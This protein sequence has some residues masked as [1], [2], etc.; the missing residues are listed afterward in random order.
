[1]KGGGKVVRGAVDIA[2]L[3]TMPQVGCHTLHAPVS[4]CYLTRYRAASLTRTP[5]G[6]GGLS[7]NGNPPWPRTPPTALQQGLSSMT[8]MFALFTSTCMVSTTLV[9]IFLSNNA[10][11]RKSPFVF[12]QEIRFHAVASSCRCLRAFDLTNKAAAACNKMRQIHNIDS[13]PPFRL[14]RMRDD[15]A[16][17]A[18][19]SSLFLPLLSLFLT[20][21]SLLLTLSSLFRPLHSACADSAPAY[22]PRHRWPRSV[23]LS[24]CVC[25]CVCVRAGRCTRGHAD[26]DYAG[27]SASAKFREVCVTCAILVCLACY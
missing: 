18:S 12:T 26:V 8:M 17:F 11:S 2:D 15:Y 23:S 22:G 20:L 6:I 21:S 10:P 13:S 7:P 16:L 14:P 27:A 24:F 19:P 9:C 3:M 1:M 5:R 4:S 25:V